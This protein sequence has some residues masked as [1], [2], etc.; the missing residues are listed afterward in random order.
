[1]PGSSTF[2]QPASQTTPSRPWPGMR[3]LQ[4]PEDEMRQTR[5]VPSLPGHTITLHVCLYAK[6]QRSTAS[7]G[8]TAQQDEAP[9]G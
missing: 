8:S 6:A 4:I 3:P 7:K 1:M 2:K 9:A 5:A